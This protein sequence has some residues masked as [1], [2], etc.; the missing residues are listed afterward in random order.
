MKKIKELLQHSPGL[1]KAAFALAA[2]G[3]IILFSEATKVITDPWTE[4]I[5]A[6]T[7]VPAILIAGYRTFWVKKEGDKGGDA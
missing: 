4:V 7:I 6:C 2:F 1:A 3:I 5:A